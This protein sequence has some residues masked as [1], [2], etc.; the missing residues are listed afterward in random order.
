M[1]KER[2]GKPEDH[3]EPAAEENLMS[4]VTLIFGLIIGFVAGV[5]FISGGWRQALA[6][7]GACAISASK[8]PAAP[9][10]APVRMP[11]V[12]RSDQPVI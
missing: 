10:A 5:I 2:A 7:F 6:R 9:A 8:V 3:P 11:V 12:T 4:I 1:V